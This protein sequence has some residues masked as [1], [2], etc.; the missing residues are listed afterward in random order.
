MKKSTGP[1]RGRWRGPSAAYSCAPQECLIG[2][3]MATLK[4]FFLILFSKV[5]EYSEVKLKTW[6]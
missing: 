4:S 6:S 3:K 5:F 1:R 2:P